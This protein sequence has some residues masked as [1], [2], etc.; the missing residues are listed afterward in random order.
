MHRIIGVRVNGIISSGLKTIGQPKMTGSL[1]QNI[2]EGRESLPTDLYSR[3]RERSMAMTSPM[4][5]PVPP[6]H[7][8]TI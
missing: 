5:A 3:L 7:I 8:K 1:I 6:R 2:A 4:V